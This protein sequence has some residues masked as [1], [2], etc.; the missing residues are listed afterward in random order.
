MTRASVTRPR[1][2]VSDHMDR[3]V[4]RSMSALHATVASEESI[5]PQTTSLKPVIKSSCTTAL[6]NAGNVLS[7]TVRHTTPRGVNVIKS[8]D[9]EKQTEPLLGS[10]AP[11][12]PRAKSSMTRPQPQETSLIP[13]KEGTASQKTNKVRALTTRERQERKTVP[14]LTVGEQV[15]RSKD[16]SFS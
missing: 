16:R 5:P 6:Q 1:S 11:V 3:R 13:P 14:L 4:T 10:I 7:T 15:H 2:C 8:T 9:K 12:N